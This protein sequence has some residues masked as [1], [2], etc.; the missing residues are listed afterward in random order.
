M[1]KV[2]IMK[3]KFNNILK[4]IFLSSIGSLIAANGAQAIQYD[5]TSLKKDDKKNEEKKT[6]D[7]SKKHILKIHDDN[8]YLIAAHRSHRSH[9]SH[10]SHYSHRSSSSGS[11][12]KSSGSTY[13]GSSNAIYKSNT[14]SSIPKVYTLGDR[15]ITVGM[16]GND[17]REL[18]NLFIIIEYITEKE[19][20]KDASNI[21]IC[22]SKLSNAIKKFQ[23][24]AR[25][26]VDGIAGKTTIKELKIHADNYTKTAST[27]VSS[28]TVEK[29]DLGDRV[30]K[31]GM[32]GT[33]VAQ[34]KNILIDKG[35]IKGPFVKGSCL[36]DKEIEEAVIQFQENTGIDSDGIVNSLTVYFIKKAK[37]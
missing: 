9:S 30:L 21:V 4:K 24:Q 36:F 18:A 22:C 37:S 28:P 31:K 6:N 2:I 7:L 19:L 17:V 29:I 20:T 1:R 35:Y 8:S 27:T 14:S 23:K 32:K 26:E 15:G 16:S 3:D 5:Y 13:S 33:D 11:S 10:R 34:L 12:Y 25:L